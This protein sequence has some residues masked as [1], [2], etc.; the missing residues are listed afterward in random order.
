MQN[1][2]AGVVGY[3]NELVGKSKLINTFCPN[4]NTLKGELSADFASPALVLDDAFDGDYSAKADS[5]HAVWRYRL[6]FLVL[7]ADESEEARQDAFTK[8]QEL[9]RH[10]QSYIVDKNERERT[11]GGK[12]FY[13][14]VEAQKL[15]SIPLY[16]SAGLVGVSM[17]FSLVQNLDL[18]YKNAEWH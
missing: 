1:D 6:L 15:A 10:V 8:A 2:Y 13:L 11:K 16:T 5:P 12:G 18:T 14:T 9:V 4:T 7:P 17:S 3:F